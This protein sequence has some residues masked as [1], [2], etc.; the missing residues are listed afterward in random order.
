ML[1][2]KN[3]LYQ[4]YDGVSMGSPQGPTIAN[5]F[6][7][8]IENKILQNSADFHPKLYL[9]Y[10][11]DIFCVFNNKASSDKFLDLLNKQHNNIKFTVEHASETLPFL[12]VE[13]TI[14]ES[15]IETKI[16]RKQT[17]FNLLL[18]CN[19]IYPINWKS[20]LIKCCLNLEKII[21]F[22][23]A[24]FQEKV[25]ELRSMFEENRYP[26]L[27]FDKIFKR[28]LREQDAKEKT[29][30][31]TSEKETH[32]ITI[33]YLKSKP[34]RFINNLTKIIKNKI[35]VNIVPVYKSFKIGR[36]FQLKS[37]TLL[38]L[39]SNVVYKFTY[40]CGMNL[41]YYSTVCQLDI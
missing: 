14:T 12:D 33:P 30:P 18:N 2:H 3:K 4:Q 7:A 6:L 13:V 24:L 34:R 36:Y 19:A 38:A 35:D 11:D 26:K 27:Y 16:Y 32:Y 15:G 25:K 9:R 10:V 17:H 31:D 23:T 41:T 40:S 20:D 1:M 37:N 21:C 39:C 5:F 22:T 28:F 8:D 29:I